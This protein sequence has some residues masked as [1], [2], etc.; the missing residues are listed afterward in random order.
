MDGRNSSP[1]GT[2][3]VAKSYRPGFAVIHA[4]VPSELKF[5]IVTYMHRRRF[6]TFNMAFRDLLE[7]HPEL[8]RLAAELYTEDNNA[9]AGE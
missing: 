2:S 8:A 6:Q 1:V 4:T 9:G 3:E 5:L 7:R